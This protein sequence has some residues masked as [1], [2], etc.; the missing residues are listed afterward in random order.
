LISAISNDTAGDMMFAQQ[1]FGYG[2]AGDAL[3]GISTSGNSVNVLHAIH[4]AKALD[5]CTIGLSGQNGG[6]MKQLCDATICVPYERT[7]EVQERHLPIYHA[8]S[9]M[10]EEEF[11]G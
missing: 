11:F 9:I 5:M 10:L 2:K 3:I 6:Q 8:L 4:V 7:L 1:V